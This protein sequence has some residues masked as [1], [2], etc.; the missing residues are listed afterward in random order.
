MK[1]I[2]ATLIVAMAMVFATS[3]SFGED[4]YHDDLSVYEL[5]KSIENSEIVAI[6]RVVLLTGQYRGNILPNGGGAICT[7]VL[8]RVTTMIKGEPNSG[9]KHIKFIV[10]GG[11]A[12][13]P[14]EDEVS[15][16][17]VSTQAEFTVGEQVLVLLTNNPAHDYYANYPYGRHRLIYTKYGKRLIED[18]MVTFLYQK[19]NDV[20]PMKLPLEMATNLAKAYVKDKDAAILLENDIKTEA[21]T[22]TSNVLSTTLATRIKTSAKQITDR[23]E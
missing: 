19:N 5:L 20:K 21:E 8:V 7:D 13:I 17:W 2:T 14:S 10:Q 6:G 1:S 18:D 4:V 9:S 12:Y 16:L 23:E 22:G 11:T 15:S 3:T